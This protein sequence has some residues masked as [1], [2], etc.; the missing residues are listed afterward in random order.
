M[1]MPATGKAVKYY[2]MH[3]VRFS[4]GKVVEHWGVEDSMTMMQQLGV[5][6]EPGKK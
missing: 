5:V 3:L 4:N 1:G 6:P 2:E